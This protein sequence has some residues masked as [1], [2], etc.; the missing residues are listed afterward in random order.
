MKKSTIGLICGI[1]SLAAMSIPV[2]LSIT[3]CSNAPKASP[4]NWFKYDENDSTIVTGLNEELIKDASELVFPEF[5]TDIAAGTFGQPKI[6]NNEM[7]CWPN[8]KKIDLSLTKIKS[9]RNYVQNEDNTIDG[10]FMYLSGLEEIVLP[11]NLT[12]IGDGAFSYCMKIKSVNLPKSVK[13]LGNTAFGMCSSLQDINLSNLETIGE[14]AFLGCNLNSVVLKNIN[15][16][17]RPLASG[18]ESASTFASCKNLKNLKIEND[19]KE[20]KGQMFAESGLE[21][22]VIPSNI[23]SIGFSAFSRNPLKQVIIEPNS[24]LNNLGEYAFSV[25]ANN[26]N[27]M[28]YVPN[29]SIKKIFADAGYQEQNIVIYNNI[30]EIPNI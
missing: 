24:K 2:T 15:Y 3:S 14:G 7:E 4:K 11:D 6:I 29:E 13:T 17:T 18:Q 8:I 27:P 20:I 1:A 28:F 5:V 21:K 30:N 9:L 25:D 22:V 19:V 23:E 12:T 26:Y 16:L 10:V